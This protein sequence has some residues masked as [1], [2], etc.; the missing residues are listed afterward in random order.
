MSKY[1]QEEVEISPEENINDV[2]QIFRRLEDMASDEMKH[3]L[4]KKLKETPFLIALNYE[5]SKGTYK[6]PS[7][8][9]LGEQYT[10]DKHLDIYFEGNR[11]AWYL[12]EIYRSIIDVATLKELSCK[13]KI[14]IIYREANWNGHVTI[15]NARADYARGLNGFDPDCEIDGFEYALKNINIERAK[16]IWNILKK[17]YKRIYGTVESATR[18][19]WSNLTEEE[20]FSKMGELL[21]TY[22]WLPDTGGNFHKPSEILLSE[23]HGEFD[24]ES[25]DAKCVAE[26]LKF[27]TVEEDQLLEQLPDEFKDVYKEIKSL[28]EKN[29]KKAIEFIKSLKVDAERISVDE[30][31]NEIRNKL[32]EALDTPSQGG[33]DSAPSRDWDGLTPEE[34]EKTRKEYGNEI[35]DRLNNMQLKLKPKISRN[36]E[37]IDRI[38]P[39]AFLLEQYN[40]HCQICNIQLDL[41]NKNPLFNTVHLVKIEGKHVWA[42]MEFNVLCLCPNCQAL[43]DHG[44]RDLKNILETA[45]EVSRGEVA[46]EE[47]D[48][49]RGD[50]HIIN[51]KVAGKER[52]IFY[53][54]KHM[55]QLAA[56]I[57]QT[58]EKEEEE[59][60]DTKKETTNERTEN[61]KPHTDLENGKTLDNSK[62]DPL[63]LIIKAFVRLK[64]GNDWVNLADLGNSVKQIDS[65]FNPRTYG[66]DKLNQIIRTYHDVFEIKGQ[67]PVYIR[68]KKKE[69]LQG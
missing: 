58:A 54:P 10:E 17:D 15:R 43:M 19:D 47:V 44:G 5:N 30:S 59:E 18:Q 8:I 67:S 22:Q 40:G 31:Q 53:T 62:R 7:D 36:P 20:K 14:H 56:F 49:R 45:K 63:Q 1:S 51:V 32:E 65:N 42:N 34:E 55:Q 69:L 26:E 48:E 3:K 23:L 4:F 12:A 27:K 50:Y 52:E 41:P 68:I 2:K 37:F 28:S 29:R 13:T 35:A 33:R 64:E 9:Y 66:Y 39:K 16:I 24:K 25:L 60:Y 61:L 6:K 46:P 38:N 57:E 11:E 21:I